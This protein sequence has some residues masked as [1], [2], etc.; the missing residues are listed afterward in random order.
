ME[1]QNAIG[2]LAALA[3]EPLI[4]A[5]AR[6]VLATGPSRNLQWSMSRRGI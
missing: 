2:A 6:Q 4:Q 3:Q 5:Q 1:I